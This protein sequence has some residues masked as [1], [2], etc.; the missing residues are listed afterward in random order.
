MKFIQRLG[1]YIS[2]FIV[3]IIIL[4]FFLNGKQA[5]CAYG[6]DARVKKN[7][8]LKKKVFTTSALT[9]FKQLQIDTASYTKLLERSD[10][11]FS[12]SQTELD[13]CKIYALETSTEQQSLLLTVKNCDSTAYILSLKADKR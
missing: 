10:V 4:L 2:G 12:Q 9:E 1:Y 7:I 5:S 6:L 8:G 11:D 13:T 3:G